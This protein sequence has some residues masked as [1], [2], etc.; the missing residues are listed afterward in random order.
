M[1]IGLDEDKY[2]LNFFFKTCSLFL[3]TFCIFFF[4]FLYQQTPLHNATKEGHEYTVDS[5]VKKG[6]NIDIQDKAGVSMTTL[7]QG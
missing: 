7:L 1:Q 6:A 2:H 5:L 3:T 4:C